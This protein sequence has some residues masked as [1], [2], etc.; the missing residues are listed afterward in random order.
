[1]VRVPLYDLL[2][3]VRMCGFQVR[4][5]WLV[6]LKLKASPQLRHVKCLIPPATHLRGIS[7][8]QKWKVLEDVEQELLR[9][10]GPVHN[11]FTLL[12][13]LFPNPLANLWWALTRGAVTALLSSFHTLHAEI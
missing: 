3:E 5:S 2:D 12:A 1:M 8:V 9:Q 13:H 11:S 10:S 4:A 6:K 7:P